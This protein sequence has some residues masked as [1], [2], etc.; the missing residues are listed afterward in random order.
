MRRVA[1]IAG[2]PASVAA[3]AQHLR[4]IWLTPAQDRLFLDGAGDRRRFLDRLVFA[5][6]PAH[7]R[8]V[9][10]YERAQRERMRLLT[11][12]PPDP[13][14]LDALEAQAAK[15]GARLAAAR[16]DTLAAL[17]AEIEARGDGAFPAAVIGLTGEWENLAARA[18]PSATSRRA[19]PAPWPHHGLETPPPAAPWSAPIA[20]TSPSFTPGA[21]GRRRNA[22]PA[23][24][25][26]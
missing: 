24:R 17:A 16:A 20:A 8:D 14:W 4:P 26:P 9:A 6:R 1:R 15:A 22:R 2:E 11:G 13:S 3:L 7:A 18:R 25:K 23:N 19:W 12:G 21:T 5:A 10:A